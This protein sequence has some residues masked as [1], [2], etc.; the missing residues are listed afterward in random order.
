MAFLI[1]CCCCASNLC[2]LQCNKSRC[3]CQKVEYSTYDSNL[4]MERDIHCYIYICMC[5]YMCVRVSYVI[6]WLMKMKWSYGDVLNAK[7]TT[8]FHPCHVLIK[9]VV[10][11]I[12]IFHIRET[13]RLDKVIHI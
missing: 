4:D 6:L 3:M 9:D 10:I 12:L 7:P 8:G 5:I 2:S 13:G 11:S 1:Y